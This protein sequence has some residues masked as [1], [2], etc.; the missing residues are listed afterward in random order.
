MSNSA[1]PNSKAPKT[2]AQIPTQAATVADSQPAKRGAMFARLLSI[3]VLIFNLFTILVG[4]LVGVLI[5]HVLVLH[6]KCLPKTSWP[7][8]R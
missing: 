6:E 5:Q 3:Y 1:S 2:G 8:N 7:S 4:A